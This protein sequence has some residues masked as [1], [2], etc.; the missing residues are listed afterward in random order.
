M[1]YNHGGYID[2]ALKSIDEQKTEFPFELVIGDDFSTDDT[3]EK[4]RNFSFI[5]PN[6]SVHV[7]RRQPGGSYHQLRQQEG[8]LYNFINIIENCKGKYIALLDGDDYWIDP[9]KLQKQVDFLEDHN[10]YGICFHKVNQINEFN[11]KTSIIPNGS[12]NEIFKIEDYILN[13]RTATCSILFKREILG[14]FPDWFSNLPFGDLGVILIVMK[15]SN[16]KAAVLEDNMGVYRIHAGGIHG[17][18]HR[19]KVELI[20]A[21]KQHLDFIRIIGSHLLIEKEYKRYIYQKK[22]HTY[23]LLAVLFMEN[24]KKQKYLK[25]KFSTIYYSILKIFY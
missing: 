1:T 23:A 18:Y 8:R 19:N 13:N 17:S 5:N 11:G 10:E 20:K 25:S 14:N 24:G 7:L 2:E 16:R 22:A 3:L 6:L 21:Y 12:G 15:K 4:I 9:L